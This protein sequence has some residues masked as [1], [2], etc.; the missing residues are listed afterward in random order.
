MTPSTIASTEKDDAT[1]SRNSAARHA[2]RVGSSSVCSDRV[3]E[4]S[5]IAGRN[6]RVG[7]RSEDF[8]NAADIG[9]DQRLPAAAVSS[10]T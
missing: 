1:R 6:Q 4:R 5:G 8:R 10:T 9:G 7:Q 2:A 3:R